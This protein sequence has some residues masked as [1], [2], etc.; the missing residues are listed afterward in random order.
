VWTRPRHDVVQRCASADDA[1]ADPDDNAAAGAGAH[2]R[3]AD[4]AADDRGADDVGAHDSGADDCS[5]DDCSSDDS[6]TDDSGTLAVGV[7]NG[8]LGE[9]RVRSGSGRDDRDVAG[10]QQR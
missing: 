8:V 2:D 3:G 4:R 7:H 9:R 6:G 5:C 10:R 1:G